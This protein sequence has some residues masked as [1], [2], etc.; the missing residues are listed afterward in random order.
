MMNDNETITTVI[1]TLDIPKIMARAS[2]HIPSGEHVRVYI[3]GSI[4]KV[5]MICTKSNAPMAYVTL[6]DQNGSVRVIFFP[7]VFKTY[8]PLLVNNNEVIITGMLDVTESTSFL[9]AEIIQK[10]DP[11]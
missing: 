10:K 3:S 7:D 11:E 8:E 1:T 5:E 4:E 6:N 2:L 9:I